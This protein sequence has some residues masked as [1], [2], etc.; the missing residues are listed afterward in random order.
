MAGLMTIKGLR[1][2]GVKRNHSLPQLPRKCHLSE[3]CFH[4]KPKS[5]TSFSSLYTVSISKNSKVRGIFAFGICDDTF[6][7]KSLCVCDGGS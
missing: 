7:S 1:L 2:S 6:A 3:F 5:N 4:I